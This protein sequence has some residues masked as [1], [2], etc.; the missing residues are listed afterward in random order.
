MRDRTEYLRLCHLEN[1]DRRLAA[2]KQRYH[3]KREEL[4][5]YQ[6]E[7]HKAHPEIGRKAGKKYRSKLQYKEYNRKMMAEYRSNN[8]EKLSQWNKKWRSSRKEKI[9]ES[10]RRCRLK[11]PE[12]F[13]AGWAKRRAIKRN[14]TVDMDRILEWMKLV[15]SK[16]DFI[17]H[18]CK[19]EFSTG[20]VHFDHIIPLARGGSHSIDNLCASCQ[21][22]NL[23]KGKKLTSEWRPEKVKEPS[24]I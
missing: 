10:Q 15:K 22:C 8:K 5:K 21:Q 12:T 23:S 9:A 16:P 19:F 11:N 18:H 3:D 6:S 20:K 17:C 24:D 4:L 2:H 7:Y 1:K 14:V 13:R